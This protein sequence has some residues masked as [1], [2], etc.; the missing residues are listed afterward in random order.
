MISIITS[1]V[2]GYR[3][4]IFALSLVAVASA[5]CSKAEPTKDQLL[6]QA[7]DAFAAEQYD[8]AEKEYREVLRLAPGR[9]DRA[10][11]IGHHLLRPR[12]T[13][14]GVSAAQESRGAAA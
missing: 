6:S 3:Q 9:S 8:K 5:G 14:A 4:L 2:S 10:A 11:S 7:K 1:I 12:P 13:S